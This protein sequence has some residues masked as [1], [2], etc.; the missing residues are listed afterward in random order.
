MR[1]V[2]AKHD[3]NFTLCSAFSVSLIHALVDGFF[4]HTSVLG[5]EVRNKL[6][7]AK[8][9][10]SRINARLCNFIILFIFPLQAIEQYVHIYKTNY[11]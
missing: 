4:L 9:S 10:S 5:V 2:S 6:F 7:M 1:F 11:K 3:P 8:L